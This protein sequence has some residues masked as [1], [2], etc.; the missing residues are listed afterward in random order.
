MFPAAPRDLQDMPKAVRL[1]VYGRTCES[2][3][4]GGS[5]I[6]CMVI[7]VWVSWVGG[8]SMP[9]LKDHDT[10]ERYLQRRI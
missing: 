8:L 6:C 2:L 5:D 4:M 9:R 3:S 1:A 10:T 7:D